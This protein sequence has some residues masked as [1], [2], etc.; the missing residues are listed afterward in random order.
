ME[1]EKIFHY[2]TAYWRPPNPPRPKHRFHLERIKN[3][4][5]FDIIRLFVPWNWHHR[6]PDEFV[7]DEDHEIL[8]ICDELDLRV[9]LQVNLE[10]APYWLETHTR[11]PLCERERPCLDWRAEATPAAAIPAA[12]IIRPL[13]RR[14][15]VTCV[16]SCGSS[17]RIGALVLTTVE[18]SS[19]T[20]LVLP[21]GETWRPAHCYCEASCQAFTRGWRRYGT[22]NVQR[23]LPRALRASAN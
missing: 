1:K 12:F 20:R 4:L 22:S 11:S 6:K 3:D 8:D 16:N 5:G 18:T 10:T 9:L 14:L 15:I 23:R 19:G 7:F 17:T 2:G 21:H 13:V